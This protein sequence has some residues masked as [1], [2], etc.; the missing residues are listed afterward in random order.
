[1]LR[2]RSDDPPGCIS[3]QPRA[4]T[5]CLPL[6]DRPPSKSGGVELLDPAS[7][8]ARAFS[9]PLGPALSGL[10]R[11]RAAEPFQFVTVSRSPDPPRVAHNRRKERTC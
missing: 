2:A 9:M 4:D 11:V 6:Y 7:N 8:E 10:W 5:P 1:M 3:K